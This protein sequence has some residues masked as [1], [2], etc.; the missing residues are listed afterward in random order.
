MERASVSILAKGLSYKFYRDLRGAGDPALKVYNFWKEE[1]VRHDAMDC[2]I[3]LAEVLVSM[4]V[5]IVVTRRVDKLMYI[6]NHKIWIKSPSGNTTRHLPLFDALRVIRRRGW[7][8]AEV[9]LVEP[10][11]CKPK[12]KGVWREGVIKKWIA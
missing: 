1:A 10:K 6:N 3:S 9:E 11:R 5:A 8:F 2:W 4:M 12:S 7:R